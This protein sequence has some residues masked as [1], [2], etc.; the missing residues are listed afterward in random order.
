ME[1]L[2]AMEGCDSAHMHA[3]THLHLAFTRGVLPY[4]F[5]MPSSSQDFVGVKGS[6]KKKKEGYEGGGFK[7]TALQY[8]GILIVTLF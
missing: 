7:S 2:G 1:R 6:A 8:L 3:P 5:H 4:L